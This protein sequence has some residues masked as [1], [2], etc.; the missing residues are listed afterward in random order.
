MG[1]EREPGRWW[2]RWR[3]REEASE[4]REGPK[5]GSRPAEAGR[6]AA[7]EEG[8]VEERAR[9]WQRGRRR[10]TWGQRR[11]RGSGAA[12][13]PAAPQVEVAARGGTEGGG[14]SERARKTRRERAGRTEARGWPALEGSQA[15]GLQKEEQTS[16]KDIPHPHCMFTVLI[17]RNCSPTAAQTVTA[18]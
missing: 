1:W 2:W 3:E 8:S 7:G 10:E 15:G 17:Q 18:S 6:P 13:S 4:E 14:A 9:G 5:S 12:S 16:I 11:R